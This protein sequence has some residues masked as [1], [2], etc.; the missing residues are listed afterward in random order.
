MNP[1]QKEKIILGF[2]YITLFLSLFLLP[3]II[4]WVAQNGVGEL[5][6][7][8]L[9]GTPSMRTTESRL[10]THGV[11]PQIVGSAYLVFLCTLVG[12]PIGIMSAIYLTEYAPQ[13]IITKTIRF[14]T[15]TLA[16]IPSIIIGMFGMEFFSYQLGLQTSL[17]SGA[18]SLSIM[19]LPFVIR[20]SEESIKTVPKE[21]R[22]ASLA[23]GASKWET[24]TKVVIPAAIPGILTGV[25]LAMGRAIGE[26][27]VLILTTGGGM[28][29]KI[30]SRLTSPVGSLPVYIYLIAKESVHPELINRAYSA[31]LV[32]LVIFLAMSVSALLIR[33]HYM[34]KLGK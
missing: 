16:G 20:A 4:I 1:I 6:W 29:R 13:N 5:N 8:F 26:T 24:I 17:L 32:L 11:F 7:T 10:A 31:S 12:T 21:Y 28:Q 33:N 3:V 23:V 30:P 14:F 15:E 25:L 34:R 9:T 27:A 2:M 19:T 18:L 22:E